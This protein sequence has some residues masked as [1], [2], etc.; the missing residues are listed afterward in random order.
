MSNSY[1]SNVNTYVSVIGNTNPYVPGAIANDLASFNT[2]GQIQDSGYSV[3]NTIISSSNT[4]LPTSYV[5]LQAIGA[6]VTSSKS[7]RGGYDASS[8]LFPTMGGSGAAGAILSGDVWN[9]TVNGT[10]GGEAV[11]VGNT[12][13]ALV[14]TPGQTAGNW[15]ISNTLT[16]VIITSPATSQY[17]R[18]NGSAWVNAT[19][20]AGDLPLAT[21]IASGAVSITSQS[22]AGIKTFTNY[23]QSLAFFADQETTATN[24]GTVQL[25]NASKQNQRFT[26]TLSQ[27]VYMPD[28]T[29]LPL[30]ATYQ[31][32]NNSTGGST[33]IYAFGNGQI[34]TCA[35]GAFTTMVLTDN[36]TAAGVWDNHSLL[37]AGAIFGLTGLTYSGGTISFAN[38]N[39]SATTNQVTLGASAHQTIINA[40][41]P[42]GANVTFTIP[43]AAATNSVQPLG[44]ATTSNWL[45]YISSDGAQHL[46]QPAFT[47][48]S[49]TATA[50]QIPS[51]LNATV[52]SGST[53]PIVRSIYTGAQSTTSGGATQNVQDNG[54]AITNG[55]R[56]GSF[57]FLSVYDNTHTY[58]VGAA[59]RAFATQTWTSTANG[60]QLQFL[61]TANNS[62]TQ[63]TALTLDQDQSA[64]FANTVNATTFAGALTG[65]ANTSTNISS[66]TANQ[67]LYQSAANTTAKLAVN[68]TATVQALTQVS[69]GAPTW[70]TLATA[71]LSDITTGFWVPTD[72]SGAGLTFTSDSCVY[73]Q[74]GKIIIV[75][76]KITYPATADA[77]NTLISGLPF[78]VVSATSST[79]GG[80]PVNS[81]S[82]ASTWYLCL[83]NSITFELI[84]STTTNRYTNANLSGKTIYFTLTYRSA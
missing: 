14:D 67:L 5:V 58:V 22:F 69:S 61:T 76:G 75:T 31:I 81:S 84:S 40:P 70:T 24:G 12:I 11:V 33:L 6:A 72:A 45:Q 46:S 79:Y 48:I 35:R 55:N 18:Y 43:N 28:A 34:Y 3:N 16:D 59:T 37:P 10:L 82:L 7:F 17:V 62:T 4:T 38:G 32:N 77:S 57:S 54:T 64:T 74:I 65:N 80:F 73:T 1:Q 20:Q 39:F 68:S 71:N 8:N 21:S 25:T 66:G 50:A 26:G 53:N 49:G 15:L 78:T 42:S 51:T 83:Q 2:V 60:T 44:S 52:F 27:T 63:T 9:I 47:D 13:L 30:G 41:A 36:S 56:L 19:I 23:T 29:T